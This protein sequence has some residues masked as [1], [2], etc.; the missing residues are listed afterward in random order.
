MTNANV[1][2]LMVLLVV[3]STSPTQASVAGESQSVPPCSRAAASPEQEWWSPRPAAKRLANLNVG[4][5]R[6]V[7]LIYF[8][9]NDRPYRAEVVHSMKAM[10]RRVQTF[11]AEQMQVHG[12]GDRTF[13]FETDAAGDPMVHRVDGRH[14]DSYYLNYTYRDVREELDQVFDLWSNIYI[15]VV[16]NSIH[17]IGFWG[18]LVGGIGIYTGKSNG[19]LGMFSEESSFITMAH[20]LG[21][22][23]GL[24]HDFRDDTYIM[25][26]GPGGQ[27]S[28]CAAGLLAVHP[29]FNYDV[30]TSYIE[31]PTIELI[32]PRYPAG[33]N[34]ASVQLRVRDSDGLHQVTLFNFT[35]KPHFSAGAKEVKAC[36]RLMGE[37]GAI[38]EFDYDGVVPSAP[39]TTNLSM[40]PVH[41]IQV[42]AIDTDGDTNTGYGLF[43]LAEISP[44]HIATLEGHGGEGYGIAVAFSPDGKT[45]ATGSEYGAVKLWDA[46]TKT[47]IATLGAT[48][49]VS[50][51]AF[52]PDGATLATGSWN[53]VVKLWDATTKT[54]IATLEGHRET[55]IV[56][57]FSP[58]GATLAT[59]SDNGAVKLWDVATKT[60]IATL[61]GP[62][63]EDGVRSAAFF[64]A[65]AFSPD[66]TILAAGTVDGRVKLWDATTK[67]SIATLGATGAIYAIAFSPDGATLATGRRTTV[68]LWDIATRTNIATLGATGE[69]SS[70]AFSPDGATLATGVWSGIVKLWDATT[71]TNI[72]TFGATGSAYSVAF[73]PDGTILA[74]GASD[75]TI[76]LWDVS[77]WAESRTQSLVITSDDEQQEAEQ[78]T[79]T[80]EQQEAEQDTTTN[81]RS[82]TQTVAK[83]S[84]DGQEGPAFTQLDEPFVVS[85]LDQDSS[86]LAGAVVTFSVAAGGGLLSSASDTNPC[87]IASST[88]STTATT[89]ANGQAASRLTLGSEPGMN[90]VEATVEG[91]KPV[92]FTATAA[93]QARPHSLTKLCGDGQKGTAY[94][95]LDESFVVLLLDEDG[96]A[97]A[98]VVVSFSVAAGGGTL[99]STTATTNANGRAATRLMLGSEPGTNTVEAAVEGLEPVTFTA[100]GQ[101]SPLASLF[102]DFL[103]GKL[104]AL[105][106]SP[107]LVQNAPNPF[108]SQTIFAYFLP[109][110][111]PAR[112]EVFTLTGQRVAVLHQG[113]QQAGYHRLRWNGRDDAGR[114]VASGLYLY[115]L[116]TDE[117]ALT[118]KLMLLR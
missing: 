3:L 58:D 67:T 91:L 17:G 69:V 23:F 26:Y 13:R 46:T 34:S 15:I 59:G 70:V 42:D 86:P 19:G 74:A 63:L 102:D 20:E 66:G 85:V 114:P 24:S 84:G 41:T 65:V 71:K 103:S 98:G 99:S 88:S 104:V 50:S 62:R 108:N 53:G 111:G 100:V 40:S 92:T 30:P 105:P 4:V 12:Y 79:T 44:H 10:V 5:P 14:S 54:S 93:A 31:S 75:D 80:D 81:G 112:L 101:E 2:I 7:R 28:A 82:M 64:P 61:E 96:A 57:A 11:Y 18:G 29:Y 55:R 32:S 76:Q 90:A 68:Q 9:P 47:N 110:A 77:E 73:S 60:N 78:D 36:R 118:R 37:R 33:S 49:G 97:M 94:E 116:A 115:R 22:T 8:L 106:N 72:A 39:L 95:Q 113:P 83:V 87:T 89:D 21:H 48:E 117:V 25:S 43:I 51:V 107:Q 6:T 56:V 109:A 45:L 52:S 16:D 38:V 35:R 27:L 1:G